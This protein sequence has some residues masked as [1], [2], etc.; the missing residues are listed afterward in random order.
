VSR[1]VEEV[2]VL[3][4][5]LR[6]RAVIPSRRRCAP[7][8]AG[9]AAGGLLVGVVSTVGHAGTASLDG[10]AADAAA[11]SALLAARS[12]PGLAAPGPPTIRVPPL[13]AVQ[14]PAP[15]TL[16]APEP[17]EQPAPARADAPRPSPT[18]RATAPRRMDSEPS[19]APIRVAPQRPTPPPDPAPVAAAPR[20][21]GPAAAVVAATNGER[22]AAGC[23]TLTTDAR[24]TA[25]A[26]SHAEDMADNDYFSHTGQDGRDFA[27]RA[28]AEGHSSPG[29]ENIAQGQPDAESVVEA[30]MGSAGH[31]RNILDCSFTSI[32]VGH[33]DRGD[34]WVQVFGR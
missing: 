26:Q 30:W 33:D 2:L 7:L 28:R 8:L 23:D 14:V 6:Y 31:R 10:P 32:G 16:P 18:T 34:Y 27:D 21:S 4:G 25:S 12:A 29:G 3:T 22:E 5:L 11:P 19:P 13:P 9:L 17:P 24:L 20:A 1:T 15:P